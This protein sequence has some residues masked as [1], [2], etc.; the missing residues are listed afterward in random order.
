MRIK[1]FDLAKKLSAH[2]DHPQHKLGAVICRNSKVVSLGFNK[3]KTSP[4]SPHKF[5]RLHAEIC[6]ILNARVD[7]SGCDI[8]IYRETKSGEL[9]KSFPCATCFQAL[10]GANIRN[11]YY[12]DI[13]KY[14]EMNIA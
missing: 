9:G 7:I 12:T 4:R 8:Y 5:N 14:G 1:F 13:G 6:A 10:K 3:N 11:I 2:S